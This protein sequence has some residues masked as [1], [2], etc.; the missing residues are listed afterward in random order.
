MLF[1]D[2]AK[3]IIRDQNT[4][5][6]TMFFVVLTALLM[7]FSGSTFLN[8]LLIAHPI[9]LVVFWGVCAWLTF[10]AILLALYDLLVVRAHARA[11]RREL[12]KEALKKDL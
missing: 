6:H 11:L 12:L 4:R 3:G 9:V 10:L 7:V 2:I 8:G 5:R 1:A